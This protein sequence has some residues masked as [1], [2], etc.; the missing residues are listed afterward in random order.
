MISIIIATYGEE[1]WH[2]LALTRALPSVEHY[3]E[4]EILVG[5]DPDASIAQVRNSLA[6]EATGR[7]LCFL[8]ADDELAPGYLEAMERAAASKYLLNPRVRKIVRG[9][10]H[11]P[12]FYPTCNLLTGNYLVIGTVVERSLFE[13]AG[14]FEDYPHGFED[15]SL[16]YKCT[17]LGAKVKP[18]PGAIYIQHVN[19][20]S[21]H[22]MGWRDRNYQVSTHVR[23]QT[24]LEAWKP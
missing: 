17:R 1:S 14:G 9:H 4:N 11:P 20:K 8:D 19:P 12:R 21:K 22:R 7:W 10:H 3:Q 5:H 13:R 15:W 6:R 23:V 2:E 16:W 18:V 24:E